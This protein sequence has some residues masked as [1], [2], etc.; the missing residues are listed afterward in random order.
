MSRAGLDVHE[1]I[2]KGKNFGRRAVRKTKRRK[3]IA[4]WAELEV[5]RTEHFRAGERLNY[6]LE[7]GNGVRYKTMRWKHKKTEDSP[8]KQMQVDHKARK[9]Q[10]ES[11]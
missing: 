9:T 10:S 3:G 7:A 2:I 8:W 1:D 5:Q 4:P 6:P 11:Q